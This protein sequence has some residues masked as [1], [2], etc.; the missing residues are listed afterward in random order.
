MSPSS[1]WTTSRPRGPIRAFTPGVVLPLAHFPL[2]PI[3]SGGHARAY[4]RSPRTLPAPPREPQFAP[5][6][7]DVRRRLGVVFHVS[8]VRAGTEPPTRGDA[9]AF[10]GRPR[11]DGGR[12]SPGG[13]NQEL[14][15]L[16]AFSKF[17]LREG[18]LPADPTDGVPFLREAPRDPAVLG[19]DELR[20]LF[21]AAAETTEVS[22]RARDLAILSL[23][24]QLGLRVHELVALD[25]DQVDIASA[26]LLG[27]KGKGGTVHELPLNAPTLTLLV[28]W[29]AERSS[30][31]AEG[32]PALFV[33]S[34]G[35]RLGVRSVQRRL[36]RLRS[37]IGTSKRLTPHSLRHTCATLALTLGADLSTVSELLRHSDLNT[38]RRYLHLV[39]ERRR[40]AVRRLATSIPTTVLP[41]AVANPVNTDARAPSNTEPP[42][43]GVRLRAMPNTAPPPP[44]AAPA[45]LD[46]HDEVGDI[47]MAA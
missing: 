42:P 17:A 22:R 9:E 33:S 8:R 43:S 1:S 37:E 19:L 6:G 38:T 7:E 41:A 45:P 31:A 30:R 20:R 35:S 5:N 46:V 15:A 39:D 40:E 47:G 11:R 36:V 3:H 25:L 32:E 14:Q 18:R 26:T 4:A 21:T 29:I 16:R 13:R 23:L 28:A 34:R 10:L 24:S 12:R 27:V 2:E 44:F